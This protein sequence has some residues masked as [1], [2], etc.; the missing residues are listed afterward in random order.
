MSLN[1]RRFGALAL[2]LVLA[3]GCAQDHAPAA[4]TAPA[5]PAATSTVSAAGT[6]SGDL[7][8]TLGSTVGGLTSTLGLTKVNGLLR[9]TPLA[10]DITVVKS[11]G[12]QGGTL[13]IPE[14]GVSVV[15][16]YGALSTTTQ[17]SMTARKGALVA[18]DFAP[19]GVTFA[20]P[21]VFTQ[22]LNGT[23]AGLLNSLTLKLGY[24]SDPSL[25]GETTGLV[26]ELVGGLTNVLTHSFTAPVKH[27]SGYMLSW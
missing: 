9:T 3:A 5:T 17:V 22:S 1:F 6:G 10:S 23:N 15:I 14:A 18:Y 4:A 16:P 25:L 21:L 20:R 7:L 8:G 24:Y 26:S 19:H 13:G 11:I 12:I 27:F 2:G